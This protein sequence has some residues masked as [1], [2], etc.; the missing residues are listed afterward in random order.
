MGNKHYS[1]GV[2]YGNPNDS[3]YFMCT[4]SLYGNLAEVNSMIEQRYGDQIDKGLITSITINI[5]G[6]F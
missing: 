6:P 1:F 3:H 2:T 4:D 5:E